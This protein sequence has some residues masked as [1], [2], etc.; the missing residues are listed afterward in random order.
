MLSKIIPHITSDG[1][2]TLYIPELEEHYHS[3]HGAIQESVHVFIEAGLR[4]TLSPSLRIL[5]V[6]FGTGLNALL[7]CADGVN[8][9][10][11]IYYTAIECYPMD[12][13]LAQKL[14]YPDLIP[15]SNGRRIFENMHRSAWN[16]AYL[17]T[18][19]FTLEKIFADATTFSFSSQ[20]PYHLVYF[21]AFA[22]DK[23]PEMWS[24]ELF[25]KIYRIMT[26]EGILVTYCAKGEVRRRLLQVGFDV[27]RLAGP[28]GKRE[29]L[30]AVKK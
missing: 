26:S 5:E 15:I 10:R 25:E 17:L 28:P 19:S 12:V 6:G 1:S 23:Q 9:G 27:E 20:S 11:S 29:M 21:D 16:E 18:E 3:V 4:C 24:L 7:S 8:T 13:S 14:N 22:P 2:H 30:R